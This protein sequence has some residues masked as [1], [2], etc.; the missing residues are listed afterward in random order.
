M[1]VDHCIET[2]RLALACQADTTPSFI[3]RDPEAAWGERADFNV[4]RLWEA[5]AVDGGERGVLILRLIPAE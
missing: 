3:M 2:L 5:A 4:P 1:H